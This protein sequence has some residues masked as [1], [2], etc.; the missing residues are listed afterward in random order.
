[1]KRTIKL[2]VLSLALAAGLIGMGSTAW[3]LPDGG[4]TLTPENPD[5]PALDQKAMAP[6]RALSDA[7]SSISEAITPAVVHIV[8]VGDA[9]ER[10]SRFQGDDEEE[11]EQ[12]LRPFGPRGFSMPPD[13]RFHRFG[14]Q[15][16]DDKRPR[17]ASQGSGFIINGREGYIMTNSHVVADA[18][19]IRVS[20]NDRRVFD[21]EVVGVDPGSDVALIRLENAP[22]D[23]P[24]LP[25]G[26][27]GSLRVGEI[28]LAVGS[29]FGQRQS[30][31][32]GIV[33]AIGRGAVGIA[34]Y[35]YHIQTDAPINPGNSGGPLINLRGEVVGINTA[36]ASNGGGNDG[37]GFAI[38]MSMARQIA[39]QLLEF[40]EVRRGMIG[41][42]IQDVTPDT[43]LSMGVPK[44]I[45]A[46]VGEVHVGKPG[47]KAGLKEGDIIVSID[48]REMR[49]T[50]QLRNTV[51]LTPAGKTVELKVWRDGKEMTVPVTIGALE[52]KKGQ[53]ALLGGPSGPSDESVEGLG[54]GVQTLTPD[55]AE[56]LE[57][58]RN[59]K[60]VVVTRVEENS[61]ADDA[62]LKEGM[63]ILRVN[64]RDIASVADFRQAIEKLMKEG[65][66]H[67]FLLVRG[68]E[69]QVFLKIRLR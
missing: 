51:S 23:L 58:E 2:R 14:P 63:A 64:R 69:G 54:L 15:G 41:V 19:E 18:D 31:T 16:E 40:G 57:F 36:I 30:V 37:V 62:N 61:V 1:M 32:H 42:G 27:E 52:T 11:L 47:A 8:A 12:F 67:A 13:G 49:D 50:A 9:P 56:S 33:S 26:D 46:L 5:R 24:E 25:L 53:A 21:A 44:A 35:E 22:S 59:L 20:L 28:V 65:A 38:P 6:L 55:I 3:L 17:F 43:A 29:P 68:E 60:G 39:T 7:F 48:G 4:S 10:A 34:D 66:S 45:G